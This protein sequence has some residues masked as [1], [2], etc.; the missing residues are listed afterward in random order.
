MPLDKINNIILFI[1]LIA[2]LLMFAYVF[3]RN[4]RERLTIGALK[5][6]ILFFALFLVALAAA[7]IFLQYEIY[8][9]DPFSRLMIPPY[10]S[11][12][13]F[14]YNMWRVNAA[15]LLFSMLAGAFMYAAAI[16]T[17]ARFKRELF[18]EQDPYIFVLAAL[19]VGWPNFVMFLTLAAIL[20]VAQSAVVSSV[21]KDFTHRVV[22]TNVLLA[23]AVLVLLFG[24]IAG[25]YFKMWLLTI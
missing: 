14:I 20:T 7:K 10:Q 18:V 23:S 5:K 24:N 21:K 3:A 19:T 17:D 6:L 11:W 2:G 13:W 9:N 4:W 15:P 8:K 1:P 22:I 25:A 12:H 16:F